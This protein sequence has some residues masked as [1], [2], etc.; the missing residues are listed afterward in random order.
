MTKKTRSLKKRPNS[1]NSPPP[2]STRILAMEQGHVIKPHGG[3]LK[4]ALVYPNSYQVGMS[5]LGYMKVYHLLNRRDDVVCERVFFPPPEEVARIESG[6]G[7]LRSLESGLPL[8]K[9]D[10][11]A[12]SITFEMDYSNALRMLAMAGVGGA[13]PLVMAGGIAVTMNPE[14]MADHF[15]IMLIGE[16][17]GIIDP[18]MD[19]IIAKGREP[20]GLAGLPGVYAANG[21]ESTYSQEGRLTGIKPKPGYPARVPRVW[22]KQAEGEPNM[23][24]IFTPDTVFGDMALVETG[25]G[26]GRH[27]RFCAAGYS[28][29][30]TR[31]ARRRALMDLVGQA[32]E[33]NVRVGL[34]G[35]AVADHP[36][37]MEIL[38]HIVA[39]GGR[40]SI[41][42]MRLDMI[43][44][45]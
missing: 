10:V 44:Q 36:D 22:D 32:L 43:T 4:M 28:Y 39:K 33:R 14:T 45:R 8:G 9:F 41:S 2:S 29:R 40:F 34:V 24:R 5:N 38:E 31:M 13:G 37:L 26:C 18:L 23:T 1:R 21:Y 30:P 16:G 15:H 6:R 25:K 7:A 11:I 27:C 17:E 20:A 35:S 19:A 42:S 3:R 12:F